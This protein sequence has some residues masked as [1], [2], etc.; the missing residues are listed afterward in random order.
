MAERSRRLPV[1]NPA[2][3]RR[4][5]QRIPMQGQ[6]DFLA[7][8]L[9]DQGQVTARVLDLTS[10]GI[11][12]ALKRAPE[13]K[14]ITVV[15]KL[16]LRYG[17][18]IIAEVQYPHISHMDQS[19]ETLGLD[20]TP[21]KN[22]NPI[23]RQSERLQINLTV[24]ASLMCEDPVKIDTPLFFKVVDV[25]LSGLKLSTSLSN[26]H[27]LAGA[28]LHNAQLVLPLVG[29][30][31]VSCQIRHIADREGKLWLG[32]Q[33][34]DPHGP[35]REAVA[36]YAMVACHHQTVSANQYLTQLRTAKVSTRQIGHAVRIARVATR[37][38][39]LEMLHVRFAAYQAAA[40]IPPGTTAY[41][42]I[43]QYDTHALNYVARINGV[44]LA[45]FRLVCSDSLAQHFPFEKY[46][47]F[48][49]DRVQ[50]RQGVVEVCR[51]AIL[52]E[53]Q[54][55]NLLH[56]IV[57]FV[58]VESAKER[59]YIAILATRSLR[60]MYKKIGAIELPGEVPHLQREDDPMALLLLSIDD[61][62]HGR[63]MSKKVW[64]STYAK[65]VQHLVDFGFVEAPDPQARATF[66]KMLLETEAENQPT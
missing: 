14:P 9:T 2:Q 19:Q 11:G 8:L 61:Y 23:L 43:D 34:V 13:Q 28:T 10:K 54:G 65:A 25:S 29:V 44:T 7:E 49:H 27:L 33:F 58:S 37:E 24:E 22:Q 16:K 31:S 53:F 40:K 41:D 32:V 18:K 63:N 66:V 55:T 47:A 51:L 36:R 5:I 56:A 38:D 42:M 50:S 39:L 48:P 12:L 60:A 6:S 46:F 59:Q 45:T 64:E 1:P 3:E 15:E 26:K 21:A 52:P 17:R 20:L 62:I 35:V 57:Q 4:S 30:F